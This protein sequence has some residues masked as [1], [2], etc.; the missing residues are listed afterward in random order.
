MKRKILSTLFAISCLISFGQLNMTQL[1]QL[2][3]SK[4]LNDIWG[5]VDTA[6]NEYALVGVFDGLSVVDVSDPASPVEVHFEQGVNSSWRDIKTWGRYAYVSTEGGG[7]IVIIDLSP[8]P[9]TITS[10]TSF[11][12]S[13]YSFSSV[14][15][16][17]IDESGKLYIFGADNGAGGAIICDLTADPMNPV[18]L[19]RYDLN[20]FH[21]G[22]ARGDTLWGAALYQGKLYAVDVSDPANPAVLGTVSTPDQFTHN[23]W[24]SGDGETVFTTDEESGAFVTAFDVTDMQNI[25]E[26]DRVQ[27]NPG[28]G[29]IPHNV[30]VNN[31]FLVSS[32]YADG[33]LIHD[34][35]RPGNLIEVGNFDTSPSHSGDGYDGCWG[36]YPFLPSGNILASDM[37]EGL[38][39]L[40]PDYQRA[41]YLEGLVTDSIT[42]LK[43]KNVNIR[44]LSAEISTT[45][46]M[47][48]TYAFGT[49]DSGMYDIEFSH[50]D[51]ATDT[52]RDVELGNGQLTTLDHIMSSWFTA[53]QD[54]I[55]PDQPSAYPNPF[56]TG[57]TVDYYL[58]GPVSG[59]A[60]LGVFDA[61][62][63]LIEEFPLRS[64]SGSVQIGKNYPKGFYLIK[65]GNGSGMI[66]TL[67]VNKQ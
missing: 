51:Y 15:N 38:Y 22:M 45:T 25:F 59:G 67:K 9:G 5:Y 27:S 10:S 35:A 37:E 60:S 41:C 6:G 33:V 40:E 43:L 2:A 57:L 7:G 46:A 54:Q 21:D 26:T 12:G 61:T 55:S 66:K 28:S 19:G 56:K 63:R 3:Y 30:H 34:A 8:L 14:H 64:A 18:E 53:I 4:N 32:Y 62:G 65:I 42:G 31:N 52:V 47:D 48:G 13:G 23:A 36:A 1:G 44:I 24:V 39:I 17:Y 16:L 29:V 50:Q 20:Y 11:T 58:S 49:V